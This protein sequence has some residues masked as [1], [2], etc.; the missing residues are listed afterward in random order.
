MQDLKYFALKLKE[1]GIRNI[2]LAGGMQSAKNPNSWRDPMTTF[3]ELNG[4][5]IFNPVSDNADIFNKALMG[6][7]E[8]NEPYILED[9]QDVDELKEALLLR[10]TEINDMKAIKDIDLVFFYL[11]DRAGHGTKTEFDRAYDWGKLII[12]VRKLSRKKLAHW[13]KWRRYFG[14]MIDNTMIEF[15]NFPEMKNF[16]IKFLGWKD[17]GE[18]K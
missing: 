16:F 15:K 12:I 6:Y 13:N 4:V 17:V 3:F 1:K 5:K 2:Y 18:T 8:N 10:Q 9:L 11:D 7:K 14:L